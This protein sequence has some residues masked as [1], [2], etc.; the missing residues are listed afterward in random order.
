M[1]E[2]DLE[3]MSRAELIAEVRRLRSGI[4]EHRDASGHSPSVPHA[5]TPNR[6]W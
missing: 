6:N 2:D 5:A 4:R 1:D 3:G